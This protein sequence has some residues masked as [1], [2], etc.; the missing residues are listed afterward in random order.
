MPAI[1]YTGLFHARGV[2]TA[3][4]STAAIGFPIKASRTST[5]RRFANKIILEWLPGWEVGTVVLSKNRKRVDS[6]V[7][8]RPYEK[9]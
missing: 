9:K 8:R 1:D 3:K 7:L 6:W 4:D 5:S 2:S